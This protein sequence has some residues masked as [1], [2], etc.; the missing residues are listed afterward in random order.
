LPEANLWQGRKGLL[1]KI[2]LTSG[3]NFLYAARLLVQ[4]CIET[5]IAPFWGWWVKHSL[6]DFYSPS[7]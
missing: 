6:L 4:G 2:S 5:L 7:N 1:A 3:I